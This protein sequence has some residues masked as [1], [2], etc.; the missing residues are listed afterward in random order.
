MTAP[1]RG[2]WARV[3]VGLALLI[4]ASGSVMVGSPPR[5][6][7]P[8]A[9]VPTV[10]PDP[11][12]DLLGWL[13]V[14]GATRAAF[15]VWDP[16]LDEPG[17]VTRDGNGLGELATP[18]VIPGT[19]GGATP[20]I[21]P[22]GAPAATPGAGA[23]DVPAT[24][25]RDPADLGME[26]R[27]RTLGLTPGWEATHGWDVEDVVAWAVGGA[28]PGDVTILAGT[29]ERLVIRTVLLA[30]GYRETTHR[31]V[32]LF[33]VSDQPVPGPTV[34]GDAPSAANAVAILDDRLVTAMD[35]A[36]ARAAIDAATGAAPA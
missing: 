5:V 33:V 31:G 1:S 26:P 34:G 18:A 22:G 16:R 23:A 8:T 13:P 10:R 7:A 30:G 15:A 20:G 27:P 4:V 14:T 3:L 6:V 19:T 25:A 2:W 11:L 36:L 21:A 17:A 28:A 24:V 32:P 9:P 35:P 12:D 29:F